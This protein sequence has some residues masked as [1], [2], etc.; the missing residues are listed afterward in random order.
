MSEK[1][2]RCTTHIHAHSAPDRRHD[3]DDEDRFHDG[4]AGKH[5]Y[6]IHR[7]DIEEI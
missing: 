1:R 3:R 4:I 5:M 7:Y 2:R 6:D